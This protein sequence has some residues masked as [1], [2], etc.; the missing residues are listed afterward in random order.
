MAARTEQL[1]REWQALPDA[2]DLAAAV[3][4]LHAKEVETV[5]ILKALLL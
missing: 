1:A 5:E 3:R 2:D 4:A